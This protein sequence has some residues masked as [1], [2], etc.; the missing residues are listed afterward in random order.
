MSNSLFS[1]NIKKCGLLIGINYLKTTS[2]LNG[3]IN[4]CKNIKQILINVLNYKEEDLVVLTDDQPHNLPTKQN[5]IEEIE[6]LVNNVKKNDI[7]EIWLSYSGHGS[8]IKDTNGDEK[9]GL[10]EVICPLDFERNGFIS[11]DWLFENLIKVLPNDVTLFVLMDCCHS[12]TILDLPYILNDGIYQVDSKADTKNLCR[13][14][15]I[16]GC[17][18]EQTSADAM[19]DNNYSGA[20]SWAFIKSLKD[21]NFDVN[22]K[23]L[24]INMNKL[25][26]DN[27]YSQIPTLSSTKYEILQTKF[28]DSVIKNN[29]INYIVF[30]TSI[31]YWF[32]DAFWNVWSYEDNKWIYPNFLNFVGSYDKYI[33]NINLKKGNY[34]VVCVDKYGDGGQTIKIYNNNL[35]LCSLKSTGKRYEHLLTI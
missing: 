32:S 26:K 24:I 29:E 34:M 9:D 11:D 15:L 5:I 2:Q 6:K 35:L 27:K 14:V 19:I 30:E 25:M 21:C 17:R 12:G 16:S 22:M 8:Q 1:T 10:D 31:D 20:M 4:D 7:K 18:D 13:T 3:C 28:C 33:V 23:N